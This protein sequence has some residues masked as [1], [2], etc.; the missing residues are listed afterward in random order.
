MCDDF[1]LSPDLQGYYFLNA[2]SLSGHSNSNTGYLDLLRVNQ[3]MHGLEWQF[4]L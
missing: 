1:I 4:Q 3:Q 2:F